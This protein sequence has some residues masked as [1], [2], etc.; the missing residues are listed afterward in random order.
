VLQAAIEGRDTLSPRVLGFVCASSGRTTKLDP[1]FGG[2]YHVTE[3]WALVQ[4][5]PVRVC[6]ES[7]QLSGAYATR[8]TS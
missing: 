4:L 2:K 8:Q 1:R 7:I 6:Q 5:L 3:D